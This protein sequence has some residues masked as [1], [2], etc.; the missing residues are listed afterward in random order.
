MATIGDRIKK[1]REELGMTQE[2]LAHRLGYKSRSSINKIELNSNNL[3]Q[4]KIK[5]IA[6]IL[7]TTPSYIM[8]WDEEEDEGIVILD[9]VKFYR[10]P[11]FLSVAAGFG[12]KAGSEIVGYTMLPYKTKAEADESMAIKVQGDS[13]FPKIEEGDW[14]VVRK[15]SSVDSGTVA[16]VMI[17][18]EDGVVK[19][20]TYGEDWIQLHSFN[21][22]YPV[23]EFKGADVQRIRVLGKVTKVIKEM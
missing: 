5:K 11:Q 1:R 9:D 16:V 15:Q 22:M 8:G 13:M 7:N 17:D 19:K 20:V 2:E 23:R 4:S 10:T 14:V 3:T 12:A 6:D 21:P 18:D